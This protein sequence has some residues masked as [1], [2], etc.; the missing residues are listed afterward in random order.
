MIDFILVGIVAI[1]P[2]IMASTPLIS[3]LKL[4][5]AKPAPPGQ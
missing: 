3:Q 2:V 1:T 4:R 5:P